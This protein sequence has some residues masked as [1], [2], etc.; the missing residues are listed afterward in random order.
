[1]GS[2]NRFKIEYYYV[3]NNPLQPNPQGVLLY[4]NGGKMNKEIELN[5]FTI[6]DIKEHIAKCIALE[7]GRVYISIDKNICDIDEYIKIEE[8]FKNS[9]KTDKTKNYLYLS[10]K[11]FDIAENIYN[12]NISIN[13]KYK[14]GKLRLRPIVSIIKEANGSNY[15]KFSNVYKNLLIN[16]LGLEEVNRLTG[17]RVF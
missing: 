6:E 13:F 12:A 1:M 11:D 14:N 17:Y 8:K 9:L 2:E 3:N 7:S 4:I 15:L 5:E 10:K 16:N